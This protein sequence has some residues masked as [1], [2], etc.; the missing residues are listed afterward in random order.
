MEGFTTTGIGSGLLSVALAV[1]IAALGILRTRL[2]RWT[3]IL[4]QPALPALRGLRALH[5][6]H[7]GDYATWL[8]VGV[9]ALGGAVSLILR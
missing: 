6:G 4:T 2:P 7:V 5:S 3:F 8:I 1:L 9:V